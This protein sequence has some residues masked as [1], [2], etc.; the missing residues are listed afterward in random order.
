MNRRTT[1]AL[2]AGAL[3]ALAPT[4]VWAQPATAV[5]LHRATAVNTQFH[6]TF[7]DHP[8]ANNNP[9]AV[10]FATPN[11]NP[12]GAP[13]VFSANP[14]AVSFNTWN[15]R[16]AVVDQRPAA[17]TVGSSY[18]VRVSAYDGLA[19]QGRRHRGTAANTVANFTD[20]DDPALN[21]NPNAIVIV[22]HNWGRPGDPS[23]QFHNH[24]VGVWYNNNTGKWSIFNEDLAAMPVGLAFN[25]I[26]GFGAFVHRALPINLQGVSTF[27]D[28]PRTNGRQSALLLT[29]H[30]WN[31]GGSFYGIYNDSPIGVRYAPERAQWAIFNER[32]APNIAIG[33]AFNVLP[34]N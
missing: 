11:W 28:D 30:N 22:T 15:G 20:I 19:F 8:L 6:Q 17:I 26:A 33:A 32:L 34:L 14:I 31:P 9:S 13:G 3:A 29:T 5:F 7:I 1:L 4:S 12:P 24:A 16:W 18:N 23:A 21:N 2:T 10:V 25:Y 27:V